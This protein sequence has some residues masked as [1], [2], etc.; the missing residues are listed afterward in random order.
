MVC[1]AIPS[2]DVFRKN[3]LIGF[4]RNSI[5]QKSPLERNHQVGMMGQVYSAAAA[6]VVWL[7]K[8]ETYGTKTAITYIRHI[9]KQG[10]VPEKG[11]VIGLRC[12]AE[13]KF[14]QAYTK[15]KCPL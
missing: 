4:A 14:F 5:D 8:R 6:V 15:A 11:E 3:Q 12:E 1:S 9:A 10:L 13:A 2:C 7:G